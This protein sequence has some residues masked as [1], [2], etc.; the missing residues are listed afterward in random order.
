M[1]IFFLVTKSEIGGAQTYIYQLIKYLLEKGNR[2]AIMAYPGGWLEEKAKELGV[3]F[4]PNRFLSNSLNPF[5][6]LKTMKEIKKAIFDFQPNLISCHST[7]AGFWGRLAI[8]NK[9]PTIFTAHGWGFAEGAP[10]WRKM[11]ILAEKIASSYCQKIICVCETDKKLAL[12]YKIAPEDKFIVIHN[13]VEVNKIQISNSKSQNYN[14]K[15][16][17]AFVGRLTEPKDPILLLKAFNEL[18][19]KLKEKSEILII[20]EGEKRKKLEDFIKKHNLEEKVKLLG[21]LPREKVFEILRESQIFILTSNYEGFPRTVLEAMNFGLAIIASEVGGIKEAIGSN[22]GIL[23]KRG[24]E[25]GIKNALEKL[26]KNPSLARKLG[27]NAQKRAKEY[28]SLEKMLEKTEQVY[29]KVAKE[30]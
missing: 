3:K 25:E 29:Y 21:E 7:A 23:V 14:S 17:I 30:Q 5:W 27:Q 6:G 28:F 2:I 26:L 11:V 19:K 16:K 1:K 9:I 22:C 10:F 20:G 8:K 12:K 13:G 4:Y 18:E 15:I 24:D